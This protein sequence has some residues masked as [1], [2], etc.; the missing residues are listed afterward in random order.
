MRAGYV[1]RLLKRLGL[2]LQKPECRANQR[3]EEGIERWKEE[4]WP[5]LKK[6][7]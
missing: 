3:N 7:L 5:L 1:S 2:S 6:G 4:R